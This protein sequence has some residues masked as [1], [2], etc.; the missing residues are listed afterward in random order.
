M[1]R[2]TPA[3]DKTG[4]A[5]ETWPKS[6]RARVWL[7]LCAGHGHRHG[8]GHGPRSTQHGPRSTSTDHEN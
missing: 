3:P 7:R 6:Y 5:S 1:Q 8:L 4:R 2:F